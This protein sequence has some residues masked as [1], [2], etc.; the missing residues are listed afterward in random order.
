M[1]PIHL[2]KEF[3]C[4]LNNITNELMFTKCFVVNRIQSGLDLGFEVQH[5]KKYLQIFS[6]SPKYKTK[7]AQENKIEDFL[8]HRW[9]IGPVM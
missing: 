2:T 3:W 5:L 4:L 6:T 8:A 7:R 1:D 9:L